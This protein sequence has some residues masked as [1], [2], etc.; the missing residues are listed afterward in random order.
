MAPILAAVA[1]ADVKQLPR[2]RTSAGKN[3]RLVGLFD[4][5]FIWEEESG[6]AVIKLHQEH[7][8][9]QIVHL[10]KNPGLLLKSAAPLL[11]SYEPEQSAMPTHHL[12]IDALHSRFHLSHP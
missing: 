2:R 12:A 9:V 7:A 1:T 4:D 3:L 6:A 8:T 11:I 5:Y 10:A